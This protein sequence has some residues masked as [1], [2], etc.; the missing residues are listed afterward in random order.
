MGGLPWNFEAVCNVLLIDEESPYNCYYDKAMGSPYQAG[1]HDQMW[2]EWNSYA[3][4]NYKVIHH[5][6]DTWTNH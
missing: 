1:T 5:Y 2:T 4:P 3:P 6:T